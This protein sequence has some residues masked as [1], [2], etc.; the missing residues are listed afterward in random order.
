MLRLRIQG[1][2]KIGVGQRRYV[3]NIT[4]LKL[5][6]CVRKVLPEP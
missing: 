3:K 5:E 6:D 4:L 2:L 1:A